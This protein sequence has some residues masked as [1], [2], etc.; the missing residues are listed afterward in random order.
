MRVYKRIIY[1]LFLSYSLLR[2]KR[3]RERGRERN[4]IINK[5]RSR[6]VFGRDPDK[7]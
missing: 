3:N 5:S 6:F 1:T 4:K 7:G 2:F